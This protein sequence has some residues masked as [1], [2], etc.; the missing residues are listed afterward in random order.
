MASS[1]ELI[2]KAVRVRMLR[3][4]LDQKILAKNMGISTSSLSHYLSNK[5]GWQVSVLDKLLA[6]LEWDSLADIFTA[7]NDE[8]NVISALAA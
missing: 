7:A 6:P 1:N 5:I 8:N 2:S 4:G 3:L